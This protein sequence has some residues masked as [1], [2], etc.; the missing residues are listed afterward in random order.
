[1][2]EQTFLIACEGDEMPAVLSLPEGREAAVGV[3]VVVGGPQT[4]VGSHR[5]F[6]L[7]A[8]ALASAGL[9]CLRF[10]YRGMGD[11]SGAPRD[12]ERVEQ[13]I[14]AALSALRT[15]QPQLRQVVLWGLC[16]GAT[17]AAFY[18]AKHRN[19]AG[20]VMLNPWVR[21]QAGEAAALV[22]NYYG[23]RFLSWSFW[24]KLIS[25][26]MAVLARAR[27][28]FANLR[29][30]RQRAGAQATAQSLPERLGASLAEYRRP[31]LMLLSGNDFTAAEFVEAAKSGPL[32]DGLGACQVSW[33]TLTAANHTFSSANW[34][35]WVEAE[36]ISWIETLP[37]S[38]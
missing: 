28:F 5:Q 22:S 33:Q 3:L 19:V 2:S 11:A 16:D 21:T 23:R 32:R 9:A 13:D 7:L 25:G 38:P 30:S 10:D 14:D 15:R 27:E 8:R 17:A 6:V 35:G 34:R 12:F 26:E 36:T 4:R 29:L 37:G 1:M 31:V 18:A 20:L 24:R